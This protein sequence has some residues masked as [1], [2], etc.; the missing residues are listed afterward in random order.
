[1]T[2]VID[3]STQKP[4]LAKVKAAGIDSVMR[5]IG[6]GS[7]NKRLTIAER[8]QIWAHGL[9]IVLLAEG[10]ADDPLRG[11]NMGR[12]HAAQVMLDWTLLEAGRVETYFAADIDVTGANI[13]QVVDYFDGVTDVIPP[14]LVGVYG[15]KDIM[16]RLHQLG[17]AHHYFQAYAPAWGGSYPYANLVQDR[18]GVSF[19][20]GVVDIGHANTTFYGQWSKPMTPT[21][22]VELLK[23][24]TVAAHMRAFPWQYQD[25]TDKTSHDI[26]L[27][28]MRARLANIEE[29]LTVKQA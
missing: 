10:Y 1:M 20:G 6:P 17:L 21:Q 23:D 9:D 24:P 19:A 18:N 14:S 29:I 16:E 22:F 25:K 26:V 4:D 28:E 12:T 13:H 27:G 3:Y 5:Y 8:D 7:A 15:D 2:T 11:R